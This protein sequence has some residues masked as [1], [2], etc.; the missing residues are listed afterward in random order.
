[1]FSLL[2]SSS[3]LVKTMSN[4]CLDVKILSQSIFDSENCIEYSYYSESY[5]SFR[6]NCNSMLANCCD[7]V[8]VL[9]NIWQSPTKQLKLSPSGPD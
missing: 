1:M 9:S 2:P 7:V 8:T 3:E 4:V 6:L 5:K